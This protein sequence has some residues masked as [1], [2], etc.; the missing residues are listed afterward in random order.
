ML[1]VLSKRAGPR[2][3]PQAREFGTPHQRP[4]SRSI[5]KRKNHLVSLPIQTGQSLMQRMA[6]LKTHH[7]IRTCLW[8]EA[9]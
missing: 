1:V 8:L 4:Q 6:T 9:P 2:W 5:Q 7:I 3:Q